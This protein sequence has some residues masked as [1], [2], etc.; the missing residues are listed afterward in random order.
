MVEQRKNL[1]QKQY[2][3]FLYLR[4]NSQMEPKRGGG[5]ALDFKGSIGVGVQNPLLLGIV[6]NRVLGQ[7]RRLNLNLGSN[8]FAFGVRG[9]WRVIAAPAAPN[10]G[11]KSAL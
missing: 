10:C 5:R 11:P 9:V 3:I 2:G 4:C 7:E 6:R 1:A 8:P